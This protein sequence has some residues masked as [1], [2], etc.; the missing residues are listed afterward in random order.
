MT[1][2]ELLTVEDSFDI[3]GR[4]VIIT[5]LFPL[6]AKGWQSCQEPVTIVSPSGHEFDTTAQL[7][8]E[9]FSFR[10]PKNP[11]DSGWRVVL[12]I[13]GIPKEQLPIG[14][15]VLVSSDVRDAL[16]GGKNA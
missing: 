3:T 12:M 11:P 15:K 2:V 8:V 13:V 4:G 6:P 14:S 16:L 7:N 9:H 10:E 1:R 5:P